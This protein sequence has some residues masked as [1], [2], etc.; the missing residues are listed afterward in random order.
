M[1]IVRFFRSIHFNIYGSGKTEPVVTSKRIVASSFQST[2]DSNTPYY[3]DA[4]F[5][6]WESVYVHFD[7]SVFCY[8]LFLHLFLPFTIWMSPS[9][10]SQMMWLD[11]NAP[12]GQVVV[13][14]III[15]LLSSMTIVSV[16][17]Y[18]FLPDADRSHWLGAVAYPV[19]FSVMWKLSVATKY[20][21]FSPS[22]YKKVLT[23]KSWE[24]VRAY[25][26]QTLIGSN[27][28]DR[29]DDHV[30]RFEISASAFRG[31]VKNIHLIKFKLENPNKNPTARK[32]LQ[33]RK[34]DLS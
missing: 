23:F 17:M 29:Q 5:F 24:A 26:R 3:D 31:G 30:N 28:I 21:M 1:G 27:F 14:V 18:E 2:E 34:S 4:E 33:V 20:A 13:P 22:E 15:M 8:Q 6:A 25:F 12:F 7:M 19:L 32:R 10:K 11:R 16:I 9:P